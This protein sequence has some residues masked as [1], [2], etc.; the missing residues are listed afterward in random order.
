M[1]TIAIIFGI[2]ALA[3][4]PAS[5]QKLGKGGVGVDEQSEL[6]QCAAMIGT[7]ALVEDRSATDQR[8]TD[9]LPAGLRALVRMAEQQNGGGA[10]VDPLPLLKLLTA[11]SN[12]FQIVDRGQGF[13]ALQRERELAAGGSVAAGSNAASLR[14]AD[15]LLTAQVVYSD[16]NAGGNGGAIGGLLPGGLGFKT[17][18]MESQTI[19]TLVEVKTG[20]QRA[21]ATGSARKKDLSILG[22]GILANAGVGALGGAYTSTDIGKVTSLA[23][24]DAMR[25]LLTDV[26]ATMPP[27]AA[28]VPPAGAAP[29]AGAIATAPLVGAR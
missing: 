18:K 19:L 27:M 14:A 29:V 7:V 28:A 3:T 11:R 15:F 13:T 20:I 23:L 21:V 25:K 6:P 17:K 9:D 16:N 24:L 4:A 2:M 22:G 26:R 5:A 8:G 10:R 12:C 1:K